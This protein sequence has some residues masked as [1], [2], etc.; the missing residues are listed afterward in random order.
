L[1]RFTV[2]L[3][4]TGG[5]MDVLPGNGGGFSALEEAPAFVLWFPVGEEP[6]QRV[7][8]EHPKTPQSLSYDSWNKPWLPSPG[9]G[10]SVCCCDCSS[11]PSLRGNEQ[12]KEY[13]LMVKVSNLSIRFNS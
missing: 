3:G 6:G 2:G 4:E 9:K 11:V 7:S 1:R 8:D 10:F 13:R 5:N 12:Y